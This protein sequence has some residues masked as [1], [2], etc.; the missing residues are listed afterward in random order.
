MSKKVAPQAAELL[1]SLLSIHVPS[2]YLNYFELYEVVEKI[3]CYEL[4]LHEK[5]E[6]VPGALE[7]KNAVLDGFCN[8]LSILTHSFSLKR[9][10]L[11]I[12]RRRWK[13]AG[14]D[15]HYSNDYDLQAE[16]IKMTPHFAAFLKT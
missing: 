15:P 4:V 13:E 8:P 3:D 6:L 9:I 11:I 14:C 1:Q 2:S 16:G 10:Y 12:Q 7:G 5:S